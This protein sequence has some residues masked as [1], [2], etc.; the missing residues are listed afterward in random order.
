MKPLH[1][2]FKDNNGTLLRDD[3]R[4]EVFAVYFQLLFLTDD[5]LHL[6][7]E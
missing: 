1:V 2:M 7:F 3:N 6:I 4:T 5:K